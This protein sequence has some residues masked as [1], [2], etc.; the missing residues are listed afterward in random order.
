MNSIEKEIS[1]RNTNSYSTLNTL[2]P[3]TKNIW[4]VCHG[5]GYLSRFFLNYFKDLDP[6]ENY[7]IA[8]QAQ[9]KY[10][11][12]PN[13]KHVGSSWLTKENT[14]KETENV[15]RYFDSIFENEHIPKDVNLIV[16]GYSQ[17]VSV[18]LRYVASRK[19]NCAQ[20]IVMSGGIPK[21]LIPENFKFLNTKVILIYGTKDEYLNSERI[22]YERK[23]VVELFG[24]RVQIIPFDGN[25]TVNK[26]LLIS[27][28]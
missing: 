6:S 5:M 2:S 25:H 3:T 12:S 26:E 7:I 18:A 17:G 16:V 9:S 15:M 22:E 24:K 28:I 10:Y 14:I 8:P 27:L 11:L 20:L 13:F 4:F 23:R 19:L 1:F 21:E